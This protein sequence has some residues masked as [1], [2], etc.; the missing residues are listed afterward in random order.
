MTFE[1]RVA[2]LGAPGHSHDVYSC[3]CGNVAS[4]ARYRNDAVRGR[5][6]KQKTEDANI[7]LDEKFLAWA[8]R[9]TN[10][11]SGAVSIGS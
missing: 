3:E 5:G 6:A 10:S 11:P 1:V 4:A 9:K 7:K 2:R 8:T